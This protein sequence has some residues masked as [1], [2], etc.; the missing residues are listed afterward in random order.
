MNSFQFKGFE[1]AY[2]V[3]I[4]IKNWQR[5]WL[6]TCKISTMKISM[7]IRK[8]GL[9]F[10]ILLLIFSCKDS[11]EKKS[12]RKNDEV[13]SETKKDT[14]TKKDIPP[15]TEK[16]I[17]KKWNAKASA[18]QIK[19]SVKGP[20]GTVHGNLNGLRSTIVFE[21]DNL[22]ASSFS[23]RVDS[24]SISTGIKLRNSDLQKEKYLDSDKYPS[25]SFQSDK[26]QKSGIGYKAIGDLTIK[27]VTKSIE[28][29]FTFS[30]KGND[31]VFKGSFTLQRQ[32]Y[33]VGKS[34]GSIGS[35]VTIDLE[36]S[37]TK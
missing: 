5:D 4:P 17:A 35:P 20:F 33:G 7:A 15:S 1:L 34:G 2:P 19:F 27:G 10:F 30:E 22:A 3:F 23:A 31:G 36:V 37:V 28:I 13:S 25:I 11:A 9:P 24:K 29:P 32:D 16:S 6:I 14:V 8:I 21:K 26:I 18:A 12:N